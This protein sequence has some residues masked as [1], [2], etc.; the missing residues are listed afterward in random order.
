MAK[1]LTLSPRK[2][3]AIESLIS[4][5]TVSNAANY[6]G[7][8]RETLYR[9]M[10]E[11]E[12]KKAL[13]D[14]TKEAISSLSCSLVGLGD[15]ALACLDIALTSKDTPIST[16]VRAADIVLGRMLELRQ[17]FSLEDRLSKLEQALNDDE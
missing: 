12:F 2:E 9:W 14:A 15:K 1:N 5:G 11:D 4:N 10:K 6:A 17:F 3:R 16:K 7:I 13:D 8:S